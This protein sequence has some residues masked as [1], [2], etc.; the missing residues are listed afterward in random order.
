LVGGPEGQDGS[1]ASQIEAVVEELTNLSEADEVVVA[2]A[3]GATLAAGWIDQTPGLVEPEVLGSAAHELGRYRDSVQ[4]PG[5]IGTVIL[6]R[7]SARQR[8]SKT[9][10]FRHGR[11]DITNL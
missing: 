8:F 2:V 10:C 9:T 1:D 4:A 6:P 5:P 7:Q 3:A 11:Q